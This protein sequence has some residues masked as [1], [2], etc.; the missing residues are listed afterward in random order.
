MSGVVPFPPHREPADQSYDV[1]D[2]IHEVCESLESQSLGRGVNIEMDA[3]PHMM[4]EGDRQRF[5]GLLERLLCGVLDAA[6]TGGDVVVTADDDEE[7]VEVEVAHSGT[8]FFGELDSQTAAP[9]AANQTRESDE[10][11]SE[12]DR[13]VEASGGMVRASQ[14]SEGGA[15]YTITISRSSDEDSGSRKAA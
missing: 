7:C 11:P 9:N 14:R 13:I 5:Q 8:G 1:S 2:V 15:T 10:G 6:P 12:L 4:V 3:P